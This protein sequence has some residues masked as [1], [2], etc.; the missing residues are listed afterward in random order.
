MG[1]EQ[2][3]L[4]KFYLI[5]F[6][7]IC[8]PLE[9]LFEYAIITITISIVRESRPNGLFCYFKDHNI[10]FCNPYPGIYHIQSG[11]LFQTQIIVTKELDKTAHTWLKVLSEKLEKQDLENLLKKI[12]ALEL[13]FDRELADSILEVS[14][15]A[16]EKI[17]AEMR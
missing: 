5:H 1:I 14:V 6:Y 8:T 3:I 4:E 17:I 9:I 11:T 15:R 12:D 16:N 7:C 2:P 10:L 13:N